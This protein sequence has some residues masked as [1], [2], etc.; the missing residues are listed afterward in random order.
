MQLATET[1]GDVLVV[2][3]REPR[4]DASCAVVFKDSVRATLSGH[5]G[6]VLLDLSQVEFVDSS[7]L[8][9]L[10]AVMKMLGGRR[11]ELANPGEVV[12]KVLS[13]TRMDRVFVLHDSRADALSSRSAA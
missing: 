6:R 4:L 5:E 12:R 13:L 11:L 7:G 1:L 8:G 3:I 2:D 10:V 9:A